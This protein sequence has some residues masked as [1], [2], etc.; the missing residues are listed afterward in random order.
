MLA[1]IRHPRIT[2]RAAGARDRAGHR[3]VVALVNSLL[4]VMRRD[5][6]H[7]TPRRFDSYEHNRPA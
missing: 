1:E 4:P 2:D 5:T 6:S 3:S 7:G